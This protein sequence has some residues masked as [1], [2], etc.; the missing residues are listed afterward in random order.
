[1]A[2]KIKLTKQIAGFPE[3]SAMSYCRVEKVNAIKNQASCSVT[4]FS[5]DKSQVIECVDL[6]FV[7]SVADGSKNHIAQAYDHL[8]TLPEF[9]GAEDC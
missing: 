6:H 5:E 3:V 4:Y 9:A 8:K 1:M 7:P 2:L